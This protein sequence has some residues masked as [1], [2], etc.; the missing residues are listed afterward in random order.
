MS[1][2]DTTNFVTA[3]AITATPGR[4]G[5]IANNSTGINGSY[6]GDYTFFVFHQT[7][8]LTGYN[9][10][11]ANLKFQWAADDSYSDGVG[12]IP[13][14]SLNGGPLTDGSWVGGYSYVLG[15]ETTLTSGFVSG[16]NYIDFYVEGN[17]VTDGFA[18]KTLS[19]TAISVV[20]ELQTYVMLW[21]A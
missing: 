12:W 11:T 21:Q 20:P 14:F 18:L 17:G 9:A 8:D 4:D 13:K 3:T 10:S 19:F 7:F 5:W 2:F 15:N 16:I 1:S 6:I